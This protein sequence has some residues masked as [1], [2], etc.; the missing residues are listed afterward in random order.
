M[1][2]HL[3][4]ATPAAFGDPLITDETLEPLANAYRGLEVGRIARAQGAWVVCGGIHAT[5]Y[6]D[7]PRE[8]GGAHSVVRGDADVVWG[9]VLRDCAASAPAALYEG[10]R[11]S[12]EA[13][14]PARWDLMPR[15]R[16]M[17]ASVQTIRGFPKHC[18]F[19][20]VW[21]TVG[22]KPRQR[23]AGPVIEE[24]V[25]LRRRG[26][27]FIALADDNFYPVTLKDLELAR[28][29]NNLERLRE[30]ERM[31]AE[32]FALLDAMSHLPDD[33]FFSRRLRWK[34]LRILRSSTPCAKLAYGER[35]WVSKRSLLRV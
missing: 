27:R 9:D 2:L 16:Y 19:C 18:S 25:E 13:F 21:R 4:A 1:A 5:L 6:P 3:A 11:A 30:L 31:R 7:E 24:L 20:S 10:G 28:R 23:R 22:Q 8:L 15:R 26:Y 35:W 33:M 32:R 12:A 29:Q 34:P 14:L 17:W